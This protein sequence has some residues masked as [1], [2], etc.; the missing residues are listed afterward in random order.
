MQPW[1]SGVLLGGLDMKLK[2]CQHLGLLSWPQFDGRL[3]PGV[4]RRVR[5]FLMLELR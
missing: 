2:L 5:G 3:S 4:S 1:P